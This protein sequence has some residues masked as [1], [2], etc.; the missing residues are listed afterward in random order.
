MTGDVRRGALIGAGVVAGSL[1]LI[2]AGAWLAGRLA[3]ARVTPSA[4]PMPFNTA[5]AFA[6]LGAGLLA[7]VAGWTRLGWGAAAVVLAYGVL[8]L[9]EHTHG[10]APRLGHLLFTPTGSLAPSYQGISAPNTGLAF[11]LLGS[12]LLALHFGRGGLYA[13]G[14]G[15]VGAGVV[16]LAVGDLAAW[17]FANHPGQQPLLLP[18]MSLPAAVGF[19]L[20]GA[21]LAVASWSGSRGIGQTP[22][23]RVPFALGAVGLTAAMGLAQVLRYQERNQV[24]ATVDVAAAA[25]AHQVGEEVHRRVSM[26]QIAAVGWPWLVGNGRD[27]L[28]RITVMGDP[29]IRRLGWIPAD[30]KPVWVGL[31]SAATAEDAWWPGAD[32]GHRTADGGSIDVRATGSGPL[33][34]ILVPVTQGGRRTGA[35]W[36]V[37][38]AALALR[39]QLDQVLGRFAVTVREG[40]TPVFSHAVGGEGLER[41]WS[42]EAEVP[43]EGLRW[44]VRV[45]PLPATLAAAR[46]TMPVL[47]Q[48]AGMAVAVLLALTLALARAARDRA[49]EAEAAE[50][51]TLAESRE[52]EAAQQALRE[53]EERL[54]QANKL[55]A[56]GRLAGGVAHDYNNILTIIRGN[57][58]SLL[59]QAALEPLELEALEQIERAAARAAVLTARLLAFSQRQVLQPEPLEIG[60]FVTER[61]EEIGLMLG[62]HI[63]LVVESG[64]APAWTL[65]DRRWLGQVLLDLSYNAREAMAT[66]GTLTIRVHP[67]AATL[68]PQFPAVA[69]EGGMVALELVDSGRG[70]DPPTRTRL[71][72][73]FFSTKPFGQGSGLALATAYGLV[74][75]SGGQIAVD[76]EEGRGTRVGI[77]LPRHAPAAARTAPAVEGVT[78]GRVIVVA[79][80]EVGVLRFI[81]RVLQSAGS[82]VIQG[83]TGEEALTGLEQSGLTPDLLVSDIVMP[84]MSGVELADRLRARWPALPVIFVSAYTS[85]ALR[86]RGIQSLDA[87]L[88]SKPFTVE[89]LLG[90]VRRSLAPR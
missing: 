22:G 50:A 89:E 43:G 80:D 72:E 56:V 1:G 6:L 5:V 85:D 84:G 82:R 73:P 81:A 31:G 68:A 25:V 39:I 38:D 60:A 35:L 59:L 8:T 90:Q 47:T 42:R 86:E 87:Y 83:S 66:G 70:M 19:V 30:G 64:A 9:F 79:D 7:V 77:F 57:A 3:I 29:A 32:N 46:S 48:T 10:G 4:D 88:L 61:Q 33:L 37:A 11:V 49:S 40:A 28:A 34:G 20:V 16:I 71:F 63:R 67:Q 12:A 24:R 2:V 58:R 51:R 18:Q 52:R 55:E 17:P 41:L 53:S 78:S 74:R 54:R 36:L 14:T 45:W 62:P 69:V 21:G 23:L 26:G 15:L 13:L 27:S 44:N 75:Q 65:M 76:S